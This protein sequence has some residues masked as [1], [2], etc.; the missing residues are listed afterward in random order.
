MVLGSLAFALMGTFAHALR[1]RCDWQVVVLTRVALQLTF[2]LALARAA[3]VPL[4]VWRPGLLWVRSVGGSVSM[5]CMFFAYHRLPVANVLTLANT[6]PIWVAL[7]SWPWLHQPPSAAVGLAVASGVLGVALVQPPDVTEG[8]LASLLALV[9]SVFTAVA[10]I[11]LHRLRGVDAR[12]V[13]VHFSVVALAFCIAALF[14]F[15]RAFSPGE[16]WDA[17]SLLLLLG[18]GVAAITGQLFLTWAFAAGEAA[19]VSVVGL[20]QVV[21]AMA[22]DVLL[23]GYTFGPA[24]LLGVALVVAS[25][26]WLIMSRGRG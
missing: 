23:F 26:A 9:S 24:A 8:K 1:S 19:S 4:P 16:L 3:G 17:R 5:V 25:S 7:L 13:I 22:F 21:F 14:L 20:T 6:F 11:A 18:V 12:A 15:E 2:A 10:M